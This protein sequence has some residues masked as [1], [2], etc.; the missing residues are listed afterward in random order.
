LY[1]CPRWPSSSDDSK[2]LL[3]GCLC[4][5]GKAASGYCLVAWTLDSI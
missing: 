5:S 3:F 2:P 4:C 1:A